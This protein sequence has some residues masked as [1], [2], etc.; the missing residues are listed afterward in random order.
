MIKNN[1]SLSEIKK[2]LKHKGLTIIKNNKTKK[3]FKENKNFGSIPRILLCSTI[4]ISFFI[5]VPSIIDFKN[6]R[7]ILSKEFEN[8]SK[9]NFKK[10]LEGKNTNQAKKVD[11]ELNIKDLFEDIFEFDEL[12]SDVVRLNASTI[13]QLFKDTSYNLEDVR[14]KKT[15]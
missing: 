12:P 5:I 6:E 3:I 14:K 4:I 7:I 13:Q 15:S 1:F 10:T 8:N 2:Y 11:E 9:D